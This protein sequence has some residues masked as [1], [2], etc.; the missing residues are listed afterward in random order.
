MA[1]FDDLKT[2]QE[3]WANFT[4]LTMWLCIGVATTLILMA[5]FLL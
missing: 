1:Q 2:H 4:K 5:V 3:M